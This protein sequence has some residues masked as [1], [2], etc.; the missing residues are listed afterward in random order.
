MHVLKDL[1]GV[2]LPLALKLAESLAAPLPPR[3]ARNVRLPDVPNK[4]LAVI[5]VRWAGKTSFLYRPIA[6]RLAEGDRPGMPSSSR[7]RMNASSG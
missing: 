6:E 3:T 2:E 1:A 4:A 5:G 7:W